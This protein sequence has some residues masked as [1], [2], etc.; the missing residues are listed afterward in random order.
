MGSHVRLGLGTLGMVRRGKFDCMHAMPLGRRSGRSL[1]GVGGVEE[2]QPEVPTDLQE[3]PSDSWAPQTPLGAT[4]ELALGFPGP[5]WRPEMAGSHSWTLQTPLDV[6]ELLR[7]GCGPAGWPWPGA[8][9]KRARRRVLHLVPRGRR[10]LGLVVTFAE[11]TG[12]P[13]VG[14]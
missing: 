4:E 1:L 5:A 3:S 10:V 12:R 11:N 7:M 8:K 14:D 2:A 6:A 9:G 13:P